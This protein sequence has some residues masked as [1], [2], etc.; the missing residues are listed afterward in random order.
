MWAA[1]KTEVPG[2]GKRCSW[3]DCGPGFI[4]GSKYGSLSWY[5]GLGHSLLGQDFASRHQ[6]SAI[7]SELPAGE[8]S[9][10]E[11]YY[12]PLLSLSPRSAP[13]PSLP[14]ALVAPW[15]KNRGISHTFISIQMKC[16]IMQEPRTAEKQ[17]L[18]V[19]VTSLRNTHLF[20][21]I[22]GRPW[23]LGRVRSSPGL[24]SQSTSLF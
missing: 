8:L 18:A 14:A 2:P 9:H 1:G 21:R 13:Q 11:P 24:S 15:G 23:G 16:G 19:M 12:G 17:P 4:L 3:V 6:L 20:S 5:L 7:C 10:L 22:L